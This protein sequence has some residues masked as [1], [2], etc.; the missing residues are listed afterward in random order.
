MSKIAIGIDIGGSGI[1]GAPVD[2]GSGKLT[3]DRYRL[4]TPQPATPDAVGETAAKV[5]TFWS[6]KSDTAI[7]V[8]F[9]GVVQKGVVRTAANVDPAWIG[10]N[11][12]D[13][14]REHSGFDVHVMN[15]ADAAGFGEYAYGAARTEDGLVLMVTLG[16]GIGTALISDGRLVPNS[17][18]G[19]LLVD[20]V[21]AEEYAAESARDRHGLGWKEW[22][23]HVGRFLGEME[24][25]LWPDLIIIGGGVSKEYEQ[26]L[27]FF[28]LRAP[29]VPAALFNNAGIVGAAAA[30]VEEQRRAVKRAAR[31]S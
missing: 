30:A 16:T 19:H 1:K 14:I 18:L 22:A 29:V 3:A 12:R 28:D 26:F 17:E 10:T 4:A 13:V 21:D 31:H 20:G 23:S 15:D 27:P 7:G 6:P 8:T 2:L 5:I 11:L 9:P 24:R 25:L